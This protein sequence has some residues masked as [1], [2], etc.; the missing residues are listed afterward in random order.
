MQFDV[1]F[2]EENMK[3]M[4]F[5]MYNL[6]N[7]L[8]V[9]FNAVKLRLLIRVYWVIGYEVLWQG[10]VLKRKTSMHS[11]D[12]LKNFVMCVVAKLINH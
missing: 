10:E 3:L 6:L 5:Y 7:I 11:F 12:R 2:L 4:F 1:I 9:F 8:H